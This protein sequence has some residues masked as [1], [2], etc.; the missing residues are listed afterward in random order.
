MVNM[1]EHKCCVFKSS[2]KSP[3]ND[4]KGIRK[5]Y[6]YAHCIKRMGKE[7]LRLATYDNISPPEGTKLYV[8]GNI[9]LLYYSC[10]L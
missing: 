4:S 9:N 10:M 5:M 1:T 8:K 6:I 3:L 2:P 7:G